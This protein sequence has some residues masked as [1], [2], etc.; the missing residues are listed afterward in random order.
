[1]DSR[2]AIAGSKTRAEGIE[3]ERRRGSDSIM[4]RLNRVESM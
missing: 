1:M 4:V 2:K 3:S